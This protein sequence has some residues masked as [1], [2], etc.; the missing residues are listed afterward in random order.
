MPGIVDAMDV[1]SISP[2]A[3]DYVKAIWSATEWGDPPITTK[4]LAARFGTSSANVSDT[5]HRLAAQG[6]VDYRPYKPVQLTGIGAALALVMVRRHRILE[7]FLVTT[8]GY[9][10]D[11]VHDEA[12]RLEHAASD[13]LIDSLDALLGFPATDP[14]GD[15]IPTSDGRT[16]KVEGAI[17]LIDAGSGRHLIH[18]VSDSEPLNL[19]GAAAL[20]LT[21]GNIIEAHQGTDTLATMT[22]D[23]PRAV[24]RRLATAIWTTPAL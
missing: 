20:G 24:P 7:A 9:D 14:H 16:S 11:K 18:R 4:A 15:P 22:P 23:G 10:W 3:Q 1:N 8:L 2:V 19:I 6:L 17:R 13:T 21:P 12:E 5:L